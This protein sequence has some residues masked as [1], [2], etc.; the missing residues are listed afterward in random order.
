MKSRKSITS[1]LPQLFRWVMAGM[2]MFVFG[3]ASPVRAAEG[4]DLSLEVTDSGDFIEGGMGHTYT[5]TVRNVEGTLPK[6]EGNLVTLDFAIS[7]TN[8]TATAISGTGWSCDLGTL[9]CTRSDVLPVGSSYPPVT[10]TVNVA[11]DTP[12]NPNTVDQYVSVTSV[13]DVDFDNNAEFYTTTVQQ[14]ANL[15]VGKTHTP[16]VF[17]QGKQGTYTITVENLGG[18]STNGLVT[19]T[20]TLP[21][22]LTAQSI[23]GTGWSCI[24]ATLTC[25]RSDELA[26]GEVYPAITLVVSVDLDA[27]EEETN[28]V[29]VSGGGDLDTD[30]N[31]FSDVTNIDLRPDLKVTDYQLLDPVTKNPLVGNPQAG[32]PF[33]VRLSVL[34]QGG[35][36]TP[37]VFYRSVYVDGLGD[38]LPGH[39][40]D[41]MDY[42]FFSQLDIT[43]SPPHE[44]AGCLYYNDPENSTRGTFFTDENFLGI[45]AGG[46]DTQNSIVE[47]SGLDAGTYDLYFYADPTCITAEANEDNNAYGPIEITVGPYNNDTVGVFRPSNGAL[48]LKNYNTTGF[49]DL[50]LTYGLPGDYPIVGDWNGDGIDTIGIYRNGIFYLRNSNTNG[51]ADILVPFGA[52]GDQPIVGDWNG[53]GIDTIGVYR[54]ST[55]AFYLRNSNTNGSVDATFT[56]G[57]PGDIGIAGD[58]NGDGVV[59]TGVFRPSNGALYL[60]NTNAT[61]FADLVL[62]YGL[63][64][65]LPV[66]GDWNGN[67]IDTIGIYRN[68]FFYLRNSNTNGFA[69]IILELGIS[70][71]M[72]IAG[73]WDGLP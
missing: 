37:G 53:D 64:G 35:A 16:E 40:D 1:S 32:E 12:D 63:P 50:Y 62:T 10:I 66:T 52:P 21:D 34:N 8:F 24:L 26:A 2:L 18:G 3:V 47:V 4:L 11:I 38:Y 54:R 28:D 55:G 23:S 43:T 36:D 57:I 69:D 19:V 29:S 45:P 41:D 70:G 67:G 56:L 9:T 65:D 61:G 6:E 73:D 22:G 60:K 27:E 30:N 31:S 42:E 59:T 58:W 25:T 71:D 39:P 72:P 7:E 14:I 17:I 46:T 20:D 48:Y 68:G 44:F 5:L 49:A 13:G 15:T 51:F 33:L